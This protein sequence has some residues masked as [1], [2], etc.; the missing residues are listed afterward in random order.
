M[1]RTVAGQSATQTCFARCRHRLWRRYWATASRADNQVT[2]EQIRAVP[3]N[4][5]IHLKVTRCA[6]KAGSHCG[7][8]QDPCRADGRCVAVDLPFVSESWPA[9]RANK[10][11]DRLCE[12]AQADGV[13]LDFVL[14][15]LTHTFAARMQ[16]GI[17]LATLAKILGHNSIRIVERYVHPTDEN[18]K[19]A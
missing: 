3:G 16:E 8:L 9:S 11:H 6:E 14:C 15:D 19:S 13:A 10:A 4:V 18:R 2:R 5:K 17:D 7:E 1:A 12:K